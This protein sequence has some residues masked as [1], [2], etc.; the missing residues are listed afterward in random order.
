MRLLEVR[1]GSGTALVRIDEADFGR[2]SA[3]RWY[4]AGGRYARRMGPRPDRQVLYMHRE[5]LGLHPG[6]GFSVDHI[7][8]NKLDNRRC[9]LRLLTQS[10]NMQNVSAQR[11]CSSKYRGVQVYPHGGWRAACQVGGRTIVIGRF[12]EEEEAALAAALFRREHLPF[13]HEEDLIADLT[14]RSRAA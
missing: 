13:S 14:H 12:E 7:N 2:V 3:Y 8:R 6:D 4:V 11:G 10:Q 9:N 1:D 5:I